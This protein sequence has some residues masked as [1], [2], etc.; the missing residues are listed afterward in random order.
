MDYYSAVCAEVME[1]RGA[2]RRYDY[3]SVTRAAYPGAPG[4]APGGGGPGGPMGGPPGGPGMGGGGGGAAGAPGGPMVATAVLKLRG[5]PFEAT[6]NEVADWF[7]ADPSLGIPQVAPEKVHLPYERGRPSGVAFIDFSSPEAAN[8]ARAKHRQ[9]MG[10]R[11]VEIFPS[12]ASEMSK[13][14]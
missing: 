11:Y 2:A 3:N 4:G 10:S 8:A 6:A 5:L 9:M 7:N 12:D 14:M 1:T 13:H